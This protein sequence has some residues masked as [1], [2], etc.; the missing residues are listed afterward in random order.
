MNRDETI[1]RFLLS[2]NRFFRFSEVKDELKLHNQQISTSLKRLEQRGLLL[3]DIQ[4]DGHVPRNVY[5]GLDPEDLRLKVTIVDNHGELW[6]NVTYEEEDGS[7]TCI[8]GID[9]GEITGYIKQV[10]DE[11]ILQWPEWINVLAEKNKVAFRDFNLW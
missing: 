5:L 3:R 4:Y 9:L 7:S 8:V 1:L 11:L 2:E 6:A 10:D